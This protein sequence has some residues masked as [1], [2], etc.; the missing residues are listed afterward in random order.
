MWQNNPAYY[1]KHLGSHIDYEQ[2][3][4]RMWIGQEEEGEW[5]EQGKETVLEEGLYQLKFHLCQRKD[6]DFTVSYY[7]EKDVAMERVKVMELWK[8][9]CQCN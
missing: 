6:M 5:L 4:V 9:P 3:K 2:G 1:K 7:G 8:E